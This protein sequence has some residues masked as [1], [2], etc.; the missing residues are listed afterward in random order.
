MAECTY[1]FTGPDGKPV[2]IQGRA[3]FKAYL[4]NGG[5]EHFGINLQS[6]KGEAKFSFAGQSSQTAD[7]HALSSA[8]SRL[9]AGESAEKV[10]Q[11]TG[12][13]KGNDG[14]W[15]Y[16]ISDAD[17]KLKTK[18]GSYI[19]IDVKENSAGIWGEIRLGDLLDHPSLFS[20]YPHLQNMSITLKS[21]GGNGGFFR[22]DHIVLNG[23]ISPRSVALANDGPFPISKEDADRVNAEE[24][25]L[26][27]YRI[28]HEAS[29]LSVLLHEI[30]HG[31]QTVEGFATGGSPT[32]AKV[33]EEGRQMVRRD[34]AEGRI[35]EDTNPADLLPM[36]Y[37]NAYRRLAGEVEA[38]NTQARQSMTDDE[39]R[40]TPP[41]KTADVA[42]PDVIV[43]FNGKVMASAPTPANAQMSRGRNTEQ[44]HAEDFDAGLRI[45]QRAF[46]GVKIIGHASDRAP[47][48]PLSLR[49][50]IK[51][52]DAIGDVKGA[53]HEGAVHIFNN[54]T[55]DLGTLE[56]TVAHEGTHF[57]LAGMFGDDIDPVMLNINRSNPE[58]Q[59]LAKELQDK[60]GY[61]IARSTEEVLADM[62]GDMVKVK[63]WDKLVAF[64]R[65][66][67]RKHGFVREWTDNDI[68]A[69]VMRARDYAKNPRAT[70]FYRE[71]VFSREG[72]QSADLP[73]YSRVQLL[74]KTL[75]ELVQSTAFKEWFGGSK[76]KAQD[77]TPLLFMHGTPAKFEAFDS[78]KLGG[79]SS[80][81]SAGLGHFFTRDAATAQK[82][83]DGGAILKG[84]I[85]MERPYVMPMKEA[86]AFESAKDSADRRVDLQKQGYDGAVILDDQGKPWATV[87]FEPWQFKSTE[88]NG[89]FD[90]FDDRFRFS[91]ASQ[92]A[93]GALNAQQ[94]QAVENVFGKPKTMMER[95]KEFTK[96]WQKNLIQ[97]IFDQY[98]PIKELDPKAYILTRMAKGGDSTLEAMLLYGEIKVDQDGFYGVD[99]DGQNLNG[100]A[101]AMQKL[102]GEHDRFLAWVS[103]QRA[104]RLKGLGLENLMT[105]SDIAALQSLNDGSTASG[106]SRRAAYQAALIELNRFNDSIL[107][108]AVDS[109][110]V[111]EAT[112]QMYRDTPYLPFYRLSEEDT[113][114]GPVATKGIVNQSAWKKL[115]GGTDK[116]NEDLMGN[117]L[118][119]WSHMLT[120]S[121]NNRAAKQTL[122]SAVQAGIATDMTNDVVAQ[123][124]NGQPIY[125]S[126]TKGLVRYSGEIKRRIPAGQPYI[127]NGQTLVSDGTAEISY[128][129]DRYFRVDDPHLMD[130][131]ASIGFAQ[132]VPKPFSD[133]KRYLTLG[134]TVNPTFKIRNLIRDSISAIGTSKLST[135]PV[136]NVLM[137]SKGTEMMSNVRAQM[138]ASG[139]M[140]RFGSS[141]GGYSGHTRRLI[142][143]GVD[144][145]HI[146]D[147]SS[148]LANL[149]KHK[150]VPAFEAY[151]E[152]GD[153]AENVNRAAL[154]EQLVQGGMSHGEAA[155]WA[156]DLMDFSMQGKWQAVRL[157]TSVVPFMNARLQGMYK[158]GRATKAD[159]RRMGGTL[160]TVA[161]ASIAL[162]LAYQDDDDWKKREDWD[163]DNYWWFKVGDMAFRIPKPFEIGAVGSIAERSLE[164]MISDEMTG[165]RFGGRMRDLVMNQLSMNPTPQLIK[166]L[167]DLWAN[168]DSFSGRDIETQGM[169]RLRP[170]DRYNE[171]TSEVARFLGSLG[172]PN[173]AQLMMGRVE[174]LSPVQIDFLIR[175]YFS[176]LGTSATTVLDHGIRPMMDRGERPERRL[177]DTFLVGNFIETLPTGSSRY[178]TSFYEQAKEIEQMYASYHQ[179]MKEGDIEKAEEIKAENPEALAKRGLVSNLSRSI[180]AISSQMRRIE[181]DKNMDAA[182]KRE[183]LT[184]LESRRDGIARR[185]N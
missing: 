74:S 178:V 50:S 107:K 164:L 45:A 10:R 112:R 101:V 140:L 64:I 1:D 35:S 9:D 145:A 105:D 82:Y 172:L 69:L 95:V 175:G 65:D 16:E 87:A 111:D 121:A 179:A 58:T 14:K 149:W 2:R 177:K 38:R 163:R 185:M 162:M 156:R 168:K 133:F 126:N 117:L 138:L 15:R 68:A 67:L 40:A 78:S 85:K 54:A 17:A 137:G 119:N 124:I 100:F 36:A 48:V 42:D 99:Y 61:S 181:A 5:L 154:Y 88:N 93:L 127:E 171:R 132:K 128:V 66:F 34:L 31:I 142:E 157:L 27:D 32:D 53:Y 71:N 115:K 33:K 80:H 113:I 135:N 183:R 72:E 39:R 22:D 148:K 176:W 89:N 151:Q 43:M 91:R 52:A 56:F 160:A 110:L 86:Q 19:D 104:E 167:A 141:E 47:T 180:A 62:G 152:L 173:P 81:A 76:M 143:K 92:P 12:W 146:L 174:G 77:G 144:P 11:D 60:Y 125:R 3:E 161:M 21:Y 123:D 134:V 29:A 37:H 30:Q 79:A 18:K 20:A 96:D 116:L 7:K 46:P 136:K 28:T 23:A 147:D 55:P 165:K 59:A 114:Q 166:P 159:Y 130:A 131:I 97:G 8:Q 108:I 158:L 51:K 98:A 169:E 103:G 84:W 184:D 41:S 63:G 182:T 75:R 129:G 120:A 25:K 26:G 170:E 106:R 118:K 4:A 139:G 90:E 155:F 153:K 70:S 57:G 24:S 13:F 49:Q 109:G 6:D 83:A 73:K 94:Q 122:D 44:L 102:D 150:I